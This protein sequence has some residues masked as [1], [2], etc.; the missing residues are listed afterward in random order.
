MQ[1]EINNYNKEI[2]RLVHSYLTV[3][4]SQT[5]IKSYVERG[6]RLIPSILSQFPPDESLPDSIAQFCF[7]WG[8]D[9]ISDINQGIKSLESQYN[10]IITNDDG[11]SLYCSCVKMYMPAFEGVGMQRSKIRRMSIKSTDPLDLPSFDSNYFTNPR[12]R[13]ANSVVGFSAGNSPREITSLLVPKCVVLV[14][15]APFLDTLL[16]I[17][18][19]LVRTGLNPL[20]LP[21]ECYIAHLVLQVPYP[22]RGIYKI[23]YQLG[24]KNYFFAFPEYNQIPLMDTNI[25]VLFSCLNLKNVLIVF[26]H[27][28]TEQSVVFLSST[29]NN[30]TTCSYTLLSLLFPLKWSLLYVP[31]LPEKLIDYLYSPVAFVFGMHSKYRDSVY[32][33]CNGSVLIVDLDKNKIEM[34]LQAVKISQHTRAVTGNNLPAFPVHY[35]RKL[36]KRLKTVLKK[37]T[38]G[39]NI[40]LINAKL[41]SA[42]SE[43][44]REFFFQFFVSIF[45]GYQKY[46]N[47]NWKENSNKTIFDNDKFSLGFGERNCKYINK[48][49]RTQMFGIFCQARLKPKNAEEHMENL[50]FDDSIQAKLNRSKLRYTKKPT[51]FIDEVVPVNRKVHSVVNLYS[52][53]E[54]QGLIQYNVYPNFSLEIL[55]SFGLPYPIPPQFASS[56]DPVTQTCKEASLYYENDLDF[57][58]CCWIE[59]WAAVLWYQ[60][61]YDH[62]QRVKELTKVLE[63]LNTHSKC[64]PLKLYKLLLESCAEISPSLALPI[65]SVLSRSNVLINTEIIRLL[66]KIISKLFFASSASGSEQSWLLTNTEIISPTISQSS[67]KRVFIDSLNSS[68]QEVS[69]VLQDFCRNCEKELTVEDIKRGW[70]NTGDEINC[71]CGAQI[72]PNLR[73]K[74]QSDSI[75]HNRFTTETVKFLNPR[76]LKGVLDELLAENENKFRLDVE[77]TRNEN[78]FVFWNLIW[79]F[80]KADLPYEFFMPY[81]KEISPSNYININFG[82]IELKTN[83]EKECQ[84]DWDLAE[85]EEALLEFYVG[86]DSVNF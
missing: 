37:A 78:S 12:A 24:S 58:Y 64:S 36:K 31:I 9:V 75:G 3:G 80:Y 19:D 4:F 46:L 61:E 25:A 33:R 84:T 45:Q 71:D 42:A 47:E 32:A 62:T 41:D 26:R 51:K 18:K 57:V 2:C 63:T 8:T 15:K 74:I 65:F 22:P 53:Y 81:S 7:P 43:K 76:G 82:E 20:L 30:L 44:I 17:L 21:L 72:N 34:N 40:K 85:I 67:K 86:A 1:E 55:A 59:L 28:S 39:P 16:L 60:H 50:L 79:H 73:V 29:E 38:L 48:I 66:R 27:I 14:S 35:G 11:T 56:S 13:C 54:S 5:T 70:K 69:F 77:L 83:D 68:K 49:T 6:E 10:F 23:S 52:C